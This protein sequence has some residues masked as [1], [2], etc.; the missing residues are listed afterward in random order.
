M[1]RGQADD[2]FTN[3]FWQGIWHNSPLNWLSD[4]LLQKNMKKFWKPID[5]LKLFW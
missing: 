3:V 4:E 5:R 1:F 2:M